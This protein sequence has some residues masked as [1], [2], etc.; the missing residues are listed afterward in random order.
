M[1]SHAAQPEIAAEG[2]QAFH[3]AHTSINPFIHMLRTGTMLLPLGI[4]EFVKDPDTR[5]RYTR[6][7]IL[8]ATLIEQAVWAAK[9]SRRS[10]EHSEE[11]ASFAHRL[12]QERQRCEQRQ[13]Y[14]PP[15]ISFFTVL[16]QFTLP[17][18]FVSFTYFPYSPFRHLLFRHPSIIALDPPRVSRP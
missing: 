5:W 2:R 13:R 18:L 1:E 9:V 7:A 15:R 6:M 11:E 14:T 8:G 12:N 10:Q 3:R 4:A 16:L 17:S